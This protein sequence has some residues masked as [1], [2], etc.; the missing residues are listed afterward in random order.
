MTGEEIAKLL[1]YPSFDELFYLAKD[2]EG[3][4]LILSLA[5]EIGEGRGMSEAHLMTNK[6][7][8]EHLGVASGS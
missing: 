5:I 4:R 3:F 2:R 7:L 6:V 1:G 8:R